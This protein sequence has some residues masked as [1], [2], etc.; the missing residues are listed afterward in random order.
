MTSLKSP[1]CP[2]LV[3]IDGEDLVVRNI[4]ATCFG[5]AHDSGDNGETESG[6]MNDGRNPDLFGCALPIRSIEAATV[7]SPLAFKGPHIPWET[8]VRVWREATGEGNSITVRL[9]DNGPD[10]LHYPTHALDLTE[11]AAAH[12]RRDIPRDRLANE[13][14]EPGFSY[15]ILGAAPYALGKVI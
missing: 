4:I 1:H 7:L 5:G 6:V 2:W 12:F 14:E 9:I 10:V 13:F 11:A 3:E 15:R 8:L